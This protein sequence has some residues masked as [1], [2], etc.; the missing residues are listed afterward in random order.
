MNFDL[1]FCQ[2]CSLTFELAHV[3]SELW[4][5]SF[6]SILCHVVVANQADTKVR[7][8]GVEARLQHKKN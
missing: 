4:I 8:P 6:P 1:R 2:S 3:I 5:G 7:G